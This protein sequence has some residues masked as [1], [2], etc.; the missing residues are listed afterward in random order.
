MR[1]P[2]DSLLLA[3]IL[4]RNELDLTVRCIASL[5]AQTVG[6]DILVIDNDSDEDPGDALKGKFPDIFIRKNPVNRGV[7]G[8]RNI[9]ID[10]AIQNRYPY[11]LLMDNDAFADTGMVAHLFEAAKRNPKAG[12]LGPKILMDG[13]SRVIWRA[14]CTSWKWTYLHAGY[15]ILKRFYQL[16]DKPL[17]RIFDTTR[18]ENQLD[19]GQFDTEEDIDFQI[20]CTQFIKTE[21]FDSVG[22]LDEAFSPY[23]C[24]D[25]DFCI[26]AKNRGWRIIY[27]PRAFCWHRITSSFRD[28]YERSFFNTRNIL[29]LARRHLQPLYFWLLYFPDFILLTLPLMVLDNIFHKRHMRLRAVADAVAW[30]MTDIRKRKVFLSP[31]TWEKNE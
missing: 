19:R 23:G 24:E 2:S 11:V 13:A 22:R 16:I 14:G 18:G 25:I 1:Q 3:I 21:I 10:F 12:I 5:K 29:L 26:R 20:G 9:G 8:G 4:N 30:H 7:A 17:P 28:E 6:L 27:V 15:T 31:D